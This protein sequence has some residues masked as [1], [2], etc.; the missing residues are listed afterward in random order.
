MVYSFLQKFGIQAAFGV[1]ALLVVLSIV[2][3]NSRSIS[4]FEAYDIAKEYPE[5]KNELDPEAQNELIREASK[6]IVQKSEENGVGPLL[7]ISELALIIC[8]LLAIGFPV[9]LFKDDTKQL[10][11][12][13][14]I[15]GGAIAIYIVFY[16]LSS[17]K[18]AN[19]DVAYTVTEAKVT[20]AL[21]GI[22][23][24]GIVAALGA[25]VWGEINKIIKER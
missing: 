24:L 9:Y 7:G 10:I 20:G 23:S 12:T 22:I 19:V 8:S 18:V 13:G 25:L 2:F 1:G 15:L 16:A 11:K 4:Y 21:I 17:D 6:V 5:I 3:I 14:V